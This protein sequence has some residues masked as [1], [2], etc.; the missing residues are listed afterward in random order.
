MSKIENRMTGELT[1]TL[2]GYGF[3]DIPN[4]DQDIFIAKDHLNGAV[5]GDIVEIR[6]KKK[7]YN[8]RPDAEVVR[9]ISHQTQPVTVE[10]IMKKYK[11]M[12]DFPT[13]VLT[14]A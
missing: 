10:G 3:V 6:F 7:K 14:E 12:P 8:G 1:V 2:K 9:V 11:L 4:Q 13:A 5:D